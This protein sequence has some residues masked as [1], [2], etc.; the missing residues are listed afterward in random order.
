VYHVLASVTLMIIGVIVADSTVEIDR[1]VCGRLQT[2][3]FSVSCQ[4]YE[5]KLASAVR[6][7]DLDQSS[8]GW[9]II[10]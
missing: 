8:M 1:K 9:L 2:W 10:K 4:L 6:Y 5:E 3:S 7:K